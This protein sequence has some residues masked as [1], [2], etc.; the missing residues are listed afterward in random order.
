MPLQL[1]KRVRPLLSDL[2][3]AAIDKHMR[4]MCCVHAMWR[5]LLIM[6]RLKLFI[7]FTSVNP[8]NSLGPFSHSMAAPYQL[9]DEGREVGDLDSVPPETLV[10]WML[11]QMETESEAGSW[12]PSECMWMKHRF[13]TGLFTLG[14]MPVADV[15]RPAGGRYWQAHTHCTCDMQPRGACC[16]R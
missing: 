1:G 12:F 5:V 15:Q 4:R 16:C 8:L 6:S 14:D 2:R 13:A 7:G 11:L 10:D 9:H 3:K